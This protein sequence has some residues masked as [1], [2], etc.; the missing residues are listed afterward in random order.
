[1]NILKYISRQFGNP[2]G[3]GG[4]VSTF[5]MNC[6]NR[7]QYA[8]TIKQLSVQENDVVLDIGFGNGV[9]IKQLLKQNPKKIVGI[10]ISEDMISLATKRNQDAVDAGEA[11]FLKADIQSL[12]FAD[13]SFDKLYTINTVCFW[14]DIEKAFAEIK[15]VL[16]PN[17]LFVNTF[18]MKEHLEKLM[19]TKYDFKKYDI[20]ELE[21]LAVESGLEWM[22]IV[23]I[24]KN[25]SYSI[26]VKK[27]TI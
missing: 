26:C 22:G 4:R 8:V 13:H 2:T 11:E 17:G 10:E 12:P 27:P 9:F 6:I 21:K 20:T 23:E 18:Y 1:M 25:K 3:I 7:K 16:K 14:Q 24:E 19:I 15:R 5:V